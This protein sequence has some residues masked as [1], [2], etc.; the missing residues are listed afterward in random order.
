VSDAG[1]LGPLAARF[2]VAQALLLNGLGHASRVFPPLREALAG[3]APAPAALTDEVAVPAQDVGRVL[4]SAAPDWSR[5][6][7]AIGRAAAPAHSTTGH[8]GRAA[9]ARRGPG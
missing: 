1:G 5:S 8:A 4:G 6:R 3:A 9:A 2:P 7:S